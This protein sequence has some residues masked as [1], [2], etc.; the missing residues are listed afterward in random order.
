MP[1]IFRVIRKRLCRT[2]NRSYRSLGEDHLAIGALGEKIAR[3]HLLT[4]G[5][6]ILSANFRAPRGGEVDI[7]ARDGK[8]LTFVEVKTRTSRQFGRPLDAVNL[9]KQDL[10]RRGANEWL[11]LLGTRDIPWR[12]DVVEVILLAGQKPQVH[13]VLNVIDQPRP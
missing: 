5:R 6:R 1:Q 2:L 7:V 10:I 8:T 4:E 13:T 9:K 11:R 12:Y 3:A